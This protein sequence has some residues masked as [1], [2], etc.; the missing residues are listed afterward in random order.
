MSVLREYEEVVGDRTFI[1]K[2]LTKDGENVSHVV[3]T[4]KPDPD[5]RVQLQLSTDKKEITVD[6]IDAATITV[7]ALDADGAPI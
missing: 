2:E 7:Q 4:Q 3:K 5:D 6:E 1:V